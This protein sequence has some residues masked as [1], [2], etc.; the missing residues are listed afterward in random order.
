[1]KGKTGMSEQDNINSQYDELKKV[2]GDAARIKTDIN[3]NCKES[4][5]NIK[6]DFA[7]FMADNV[8][9]EFKMVAERLGLFNGFAD[10]EDKKKREK[11]VDST[12]KSFFGKM[13]SKTVQYEYLKNGGKP[14]ENTPPKCD[15]YALDLIA[16]LYASRLIPEMARALD[17]AGIEVRFTKPITNLDLEGNEDDK[18]TVIDSY[19]RGAAIQ[20]DIFEKNA[21]IED[22]IFE[23]IPDSM[24]YDKDSN[25]KGIKKSQFGALAE[26]QSKT[27]ELSMN[28]DAEKATA[29]VEAQC[30]KHFANSKNQEMLA[31]VTELIIA[32]ENEDV[33]T[34]A[35]EEALGGTDVEEGEKEENEES[36]SEEPQQNLDKL[37]AEDMD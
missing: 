27:D 2:M 35:V 16:N 7:G 36:V 28:G 1:M 30:D 13:F 17:T 23:S 5:K 4:L 19:T 9:D 26:L 20:D 14:K 29:T 25:P 34:Q 10:M 22:V 8:S 15:S 12:L 31:I 24:K 18:N 3:S 6:R 21:E 33:D 37:V 11:K 32:R